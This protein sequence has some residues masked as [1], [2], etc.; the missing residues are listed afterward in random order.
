VVGHQ[1]IKVDVRVIA[2]TNRDLAREVAEEVFRQDLYY[3]LNVFPLQLPSLRERAEDIALLTH[4]FV[5]R[6]A[7]KIGRKITR[8]PR[9]TMERLVSYPWPGNVRELEN[10]IE[11]AVILSSGPDL[12][13]SPEILPIAPVYPL[14]KEDSTRELHVENERAGGELSSLSELERSHIVATLKKTS[15]RI[16]GPNGAARILNLNPSTLR[17]RMK[18]LK[19]KRSA[20]GI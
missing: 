17:S 4:F 2:A 18:K 13:I 16:D 14:P 8:V 1:T 11:R 3:R 7:S 12:E 20:D 15:W 5:R 10:V 6:Y 19:I 9:E